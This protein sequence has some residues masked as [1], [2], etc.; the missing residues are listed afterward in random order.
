MD[1]RAVFNKYGIELSDKQ[2]EMF[3]K[4]Y[5]LLKEYNEK[6][7]L[8]NI[9]DYNDVWIKHFL[10]SCLPINC[11]DENKTLLDIGGGAGFPSIPL[12]I[13]RPDLKIT[14]IDSVNKKVEFMNVVIEQLG[15]NNIEA[16]HFRCEEMAIKS[17]YRENFDY[18]IARAV[19]P[20]STLLEYTIPFINLNGKLVLYKGNGYKNEIEMTTNTCKEL[21]C[22]LKDVVEINVSELETCRYF[23]IYGKNKSTSTKYPRKQNK[24]R[25]SPLN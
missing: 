3:E 4:Y 20:L 14:I 10:D 11:F 9:I 2:I 24:P 18:S 21:C 7:N 13:I 25:T 19:A 22:E 12:K 1:K 15:L 17:Q 5:E 16:L 23:L 6:F 8:T